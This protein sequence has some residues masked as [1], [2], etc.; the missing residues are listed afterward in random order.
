MLS[1]SDNYQ[2]GVKEM[3][4]FRVNN[5]VVTIL[6]HRMHEIVQGTEKMENHF[7]CSVKSFLSTFV[8]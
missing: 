5:H 1:L 2:T 8:H 7:L 3:F 6:I 4:T